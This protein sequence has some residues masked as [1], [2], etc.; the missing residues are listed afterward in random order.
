MISIDKFADDLIPSMNPAP[1]NWI[2]AYKKQLFFFETEAAANDSVVEW[3]DILIVLIFE[4]SL[5]QYLFW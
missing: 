1:I 4:K 3:F 2:F 5:I